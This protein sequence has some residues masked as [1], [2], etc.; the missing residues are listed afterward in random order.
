MAGALAS[1]ARL[2]NLE[3]GVRATELFF[4]ATWHPC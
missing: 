4:A 1:R 2:T 3:G